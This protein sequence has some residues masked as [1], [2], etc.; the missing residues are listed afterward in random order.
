M[1]LATLGALAGSYAMDKISQNSQNASAKKSAK[2]QAIYQDWLNQ[3]QFERQTAWEKEKM[4]NSYQWTMQDMKNAGLNPIL[5]M[6]QNGAT[7]ASAPSGAGGTSALANTRGLNLAEAFEKTNNAFIQ[8]QILDNTTAKTN[9]E[10]ANIDANTLNTLEKAK[11]ITPKERQ[12]IQ[13]SESR[14]ALN[15]TQSAKN[16]QESQK[17]HEETNQILNGIGDK[18]LGTGKGT[19]TSKIITGLSMLGGGGA[20]LKGAK[21]GYNAYKGAKTAKGFGKFIASINKQ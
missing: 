17:I 10:I 7:S 13:E 1:V 2:S 14:I 12:S 5:G 11:W 8:K 6:A 3:Q 19:T 20:L 9:A 4:L 18:L 21:L 16:V 15:A